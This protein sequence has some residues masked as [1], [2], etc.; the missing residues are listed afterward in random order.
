MK[1]LSLLRLLVL[2]LGYLYCKVTL[3][4]LFVNLCVGGR[5]HGSCLWDTYCGRL[6]AAAGVVGC[7]KEGHLGP[8]WVLRGKGHSLHILQCVS[9]RAH[10]T[11]SHTQY[12]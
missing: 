9:P 7:R 10:T 4:M 1:L 3:P 5:G 11:S 8:P 2:V 12:T 6:E